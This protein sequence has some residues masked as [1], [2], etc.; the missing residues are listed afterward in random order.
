MVKHLHP[1]ET[2]PQDAQQQAAVAM[3]HK[4]CSNLNMQRILPKS[5]TDLWH[6]LGE[7]KIVD[8]KRQ[9]LGGLIGRTCLTS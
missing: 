3:L 1:Y 2:M 5:Y 4:F 6:E 7:Q 9:C 8:D